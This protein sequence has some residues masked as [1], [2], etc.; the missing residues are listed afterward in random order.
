M[1]QEKPCDRYIYT[2]RVFSIKFKWLHTFPVWIPTL[3]YRKK[4]R[5]HSCPSEIKR[6]FWIMRHPGLFAIRKNQF[7]LAG[8][9]NC[10]NNSTW[11]WTEGTREINLGL[12]SRE[13][14]GKAREVNTNSE[15]QSIYS[16]VCAGGELWGKVIEGISEKATFELRPKWQEGTI[17]DQA[18]ES[19]CQAERSAGAKALR[20]GDRSFKEWKN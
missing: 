4:L 16:L 11:Q 15:R 6:L 17:M 5:F 3:W 9:L 20:W 18:K 8:E 1:T 2:N 12:T 14:I 7:R 19:G 13:V 10:R